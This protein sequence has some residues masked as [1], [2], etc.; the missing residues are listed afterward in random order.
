MKGLEI[1]YFDFNAQG[2]STD[3][4][5]EHSG[6]LDWEH[7][8]TQFNDFGLL[9]FSFVYFSVQNA[10]SLVQ[11]LVITFSLYLGLKL[12]SV[13]WKKQFLIWMKNFFYYFVFFNFPAWFMYQTCL[14]LQIISMKTI[15]DQNSSKND[16][17]K[18]SL[19]LSIIYF[20][21]LLLTWVVVLLK[22]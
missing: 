20:V 18:S 21:L 2:T 16:N 8:E 12:I 10:L 11:T 22:I 6:E 1:P 15:L 7:K 3:K 4:M 19:A 13:F 9:P 17:V 14:N 5:F